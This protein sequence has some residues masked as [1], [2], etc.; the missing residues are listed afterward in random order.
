MLSHLNLRLDES[1]E[2]RNLT[3]LTKVNEVGHTEQ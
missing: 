3:Q 2:W 1:K